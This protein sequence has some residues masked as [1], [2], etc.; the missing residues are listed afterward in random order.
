VTFSGV[1]IKCCV[2]VDGRNIV[3]LERATADPV[4]RDDFCSSKTLRCTVPW[5]SPVGSLKIKRESWSLAII[6]FTITT[7]NDTFC[8]EG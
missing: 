5:I 4:D 1:T 7:M 2:K 8:K 3:T 6:F